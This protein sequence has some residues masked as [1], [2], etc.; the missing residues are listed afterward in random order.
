MN[1]I[2]IILALALLAILV[3]LFVTRLQRRNCH[4]MLSL[5]N[6]SAATTATHIRVSSLTPATK[7]IQA[8]APSGWLQASNYPDFVT[9][10]PAAGGPVPVGDPLP[11]PFSIWNQNNAQ[12]DK[13]VLVEWLDQNEGV[14]CSQQLRVDCGAPEE[15]PRGEP[16]AEMEGEGAKGCRCLSVETDADPESNEFA[17]P[18]LTVEV[19]S[20]M[21]TGPLEVTVPYSIEV[22]PPNL[23]F[24]RLWQVFVL[25]E[26]D[27]EQPVTVPVNDD[28]AGNAVFTLPGPGDYTF[29]LTVTDP[30]SCAS[31]TDRDDEDT[32]D[33]DFATL[34]VTAPVTK[35]EWEQVNP[36]DPR[37]YKFTSVSDPGYGPQWS[38]TNQSDPAQPPYTATNVDVLYY[39]CPN[40]GDT[41]EVTLTTFDASGSAS[42]DTVTVTPTVKPSQADFYWDRWNSCVTEKFEVQF[43]NRSTVECPV[44]WHWDFDDGTTS[45]DQD[46]LHV[47]AIAGT[48]T[49]TL[50][51][52]VMIAGSP[53][54][55]PPASKDIK[56]Y[57]WEPPIHY[58][59]CTDGHVI[60]ETT[61]SQ[62][63]D[64]LERERVWTFKDGDPERRHGRKV[65]VCYKEAG[66]K[67]VKLKAVNEDEGECE[68]NKEVF[69]PQVSHCCRRDRTSDTK[70]FTYKNKQ[71][72][73]K[74]AF[75]YCG[76]LG[77][78]IARTKLKM[79]RKAGWYRKR[80]HKISVQIAGQVFTKADNGCFCFESHPVTPDAKDRNDKAR[81]VQRHFPQVGRFRVPNKALVSTH[82]VQ[83]DADDTPRVFDLR[84][85]EKECGCG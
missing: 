27:E 31:A 73:L 11:G 72:R 4:H 34:K 58:T 69:V 22:E 6:V 33:T 59:V 64:G 44:T 67:S 56:V 71:Y 61:A 28:L 57:H 24:T 47:F 19:G 76:S 1:P 9:W 13:R 3:L 79:K 25:D 14:V 17:E 48:Y 15:L 2:L 26:M 42:S 12:P 54:T 38:I 41:Y 37:S 23:Q 43:R 55:F 85:P 10:R 82:T 8:S 21:Q 70:G 45:T 62:T 36:C 66:L 51:M 74:I 40:M 46:P 84:L 75:R 65:R 53:H 16:A 83:V 49:V 29:Y 32:G 78:M 18:D 52:T 50:T 60:Y 68:A 80:A 77:M 81:V 39:T 20:A 5:R 7:I 63:W 30:A 35:I